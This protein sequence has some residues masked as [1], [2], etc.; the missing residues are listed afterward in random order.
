MTG[1]PKI[2][3]R[4]LAKMRRERFAADFS[5]H[6]FLHARA[7]DDIVDRLETVNRDFS[8]AVFVGAGRLTAKLTPLCGVNSIVHVDLS[9]ARLFGARPALV[10]DEDA[11]PLAAASVDLFVSLLTLHGVNDLIGA[12][13]QARA[14]LK[15]DGLFLAALFGE[16]T[17]THLRRALYAAETEIVGGVAARAP[18]FAT[19]QDCGNALSRAGY[20]MPVTDVD[21]VVARYEN[22]A[23]L[24]RDLRALGETNALMKKPPPLRRDVFARA[25][26]LFE[27]DGGKERFDIVYLTAWAPHESQPQPLR[28]GAATQSMESAV[29]K[30]S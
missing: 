4:R 16:E 15:P 21:K 22:P 13:V 25:M 18:P 14:A 27:Q 17:L 30:R 2:F 7:M 9:R 24:I 5:A 20:A 26:E 19:I 1:P 28:P 12:L 11:L 10:A 8:H 29:K 3:D 23:R 6:N